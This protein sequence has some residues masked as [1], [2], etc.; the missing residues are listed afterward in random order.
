M[1]FLVVLAYKGFAFLLNPSMNHI[2]RLQ[3]PRK[4]WISFI[5]LRFVHSQMAAVL[6][7][8]ILIPFRPLINSTYSVS[9]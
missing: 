2:E 3:N 5:D 6:I 8:S 9:L 4:H 7:A 1:H